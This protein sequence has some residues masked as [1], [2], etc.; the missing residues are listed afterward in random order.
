MGIGSAMADETI[1]NDMVSKAVDQTVAEISEKE[2]YD[3]VMLWCWVSV[4]PEESRHACILLCF[5]AMPFVRPNERGA[6]GDR[7]TMGL[8]SA[9]ADETIVNGVVSEAVDQTVAKISGKEDYDLVMLWCWVSVGPEE[10]RHACILLCFM[11]MPFVVSAYEQLDWSDF[12]LSV[13]EGVFIPGTPS[14]SFS[15]SC[16]KI[17]TS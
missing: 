1:I 4:G 13:Q 17:R 3:L 11:A 10:S 9:M 8:G 16:K 5:M 14:S 15:I 6:V 2:D 7:A 12:V